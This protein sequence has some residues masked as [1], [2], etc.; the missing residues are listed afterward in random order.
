MHVVL[1][2]LPIIFYQLLLRFDLVFPGSVSIRIDT[3]RAQHLLKF[4]TDHFET[5]RTSSSLSENV[6]VVL[7]L[8]SHYFY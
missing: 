2:Y 7:G 4:S 6:H 3:L 5:M 1:G 8:S